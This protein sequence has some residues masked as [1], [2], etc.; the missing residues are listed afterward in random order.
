MLDRGL[1]KFRL[2]HGGQVGSGHG[3]QIF[4]QTH[5]SRDRPHGVGVVARDNLQ[6][7]ARLGKSL[8]CFRHAGAQLVAKDQQAQGLQILGQGGAVAF[9]GFG[10]NGGTDGKQQHPES[11]AS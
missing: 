3:R 5:P 10:R 4:A 2:S 9:G 6:P 8:E 7:N 11:L 1:G